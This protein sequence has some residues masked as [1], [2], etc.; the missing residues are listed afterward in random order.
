MF[1]CIYRNLHIHTYAHI[2]ALEDLGDLF[3]TAVEITF[4]VWFF[5]Y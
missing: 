1:V 2:H 3:K 5:C 4:L